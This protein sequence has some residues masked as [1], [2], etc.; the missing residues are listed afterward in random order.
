MAS[1]KKRMSIALVSAML[2]AAMPFEV[3]SADGGD[4]ADDVV[5]IDEDFNKATEGEP[6]NVTYTGSIDDITATQGWTTTAMSTPR[7]RSL[8]RIM[9]IS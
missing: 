4:D 7:S 6:D 3:L 8:E 1:V 5:L 2:A 9:T